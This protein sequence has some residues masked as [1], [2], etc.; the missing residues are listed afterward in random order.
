MESTA[1]PVRSFIEF[2]IRGGAEAEF[3]RAYLDGGFLDKAIHA[4]GFLGGEF[5]KKSDVPPVYAASALWHAEE[6]YTAWQRGYGAVFSAEA[7][8]R[9]AH[10]FLKPPQGVALRVLS[11]APS[12]NEREA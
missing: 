6:D 11:R 10:C 2:H 8:E 5:L 3:E 1:M 9:L 4:H 7:L 12:V